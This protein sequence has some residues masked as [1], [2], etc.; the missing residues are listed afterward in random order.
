MPALDR[1]GDHRVVARV[2]VAHVRGVGREPVRLLGE[3]REVLDVD[4]GRHQV[5]ARAAAIGRSSGRSGRCRARCSPPRRRAGRAARP[6]RTRGW[7]PGSRRRAPP[8]PPAPA[9]RP[10]TAARGRRCPGRSSRR[11]ASPTPAAVGDL[12]GHLAGQ[13]GRI[14]QIDA[15][16]ADV[17]LGQCDVPSGR[18]SARA[19]RPGRPAAWCPP[20]TRSPA[21]RARR[22]PGSAR[23]CSSRLVE[24]GRCRSA[25]SR[26]GS[27]RRRTRAARTRSTITASA[28]AG[29][30]RTAAGTP[31]R[32][33]GSPGGRRR[34]PGREPRH[35][36]AHCLGSLIL[37]RVEVAG[38]TG[39]ARSRPAG[40]T[41][42][43]KPPGM[44]PMPGMPGMPPGSP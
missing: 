17:A 38:G 8:R 3:R 4:Q 27:A 39:P 43:G 36:S 24:G 18:G 23:A 22:R 14:I 16:V 11:R 25:S 32:S 30:P 21:A 29:P 34:L 9:R 10:A 15:Q 37:A 26:C 1:V 20:V 19:G 28:A 42:G 35:G 13:V 12:T 6:R 33:T 2:Q 40:R 7:S 41:A 31:H 5:G 44:P